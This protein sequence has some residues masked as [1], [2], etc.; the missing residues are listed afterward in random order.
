MRYSP[1]SV[2]LFRGGEM[3]ITLDAILA[4]PI[5]LSEEVRFCGL[6]AG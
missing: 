2:L 3:T 1:I 5:L 6:D 4:E